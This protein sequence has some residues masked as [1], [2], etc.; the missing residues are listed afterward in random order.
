[1]SAYYRLFR[2]ELLFSGYNENSYPLI[3]KKEVQSFDQIYC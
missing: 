2:Y 3:Y 1:M